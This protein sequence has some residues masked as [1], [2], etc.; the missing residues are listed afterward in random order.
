MKTRKKGFTV[1]ELVFVI[2]I[3]A[4]LVS[5]IAPWSVRTIQKTFARSKAAADATNLRITLIQL[6]EELIMDKS[7]NEITK[8]LAPIESRLVPGA[9]LMVNYSKPVSLNVYFVD[10]EDYYSIDYLAEVAENGLSGHSL[11]KPFTLGFWYELG[12]G[13]INEYE[14]GY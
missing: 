1:L 6:H 9:K 2:L 8:E 4:V 7:M 14:K 3:L 12:V 10:G 5:V 13:K 11:K